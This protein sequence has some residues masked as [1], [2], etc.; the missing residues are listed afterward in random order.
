MTQGLIN[1]NTRSLR[2]ANTGKHH[3][4]DECHLWELTERTS[5]VKMC[6]SVVSTLASSLSL[7]CWTEAL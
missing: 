4:Q 2:L 5:R 1:A 6:S 7:T 3:F